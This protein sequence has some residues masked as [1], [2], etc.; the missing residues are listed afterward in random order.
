MISKEF[1]DLVQS[2]GFFSSELKKYEDG[3]SYDRLST[4]KVSFN[5]DMLQMTDIS[6]LSAIAEEQSNVSRM[7]FVYG[8]IYESQNRVLQAL[9]DEYE[10]WEAKIYNV[11][12]Q[13]KSFKTEGAREKHLLQEYENEYNIYKE[14]LRTEKYKLGVLKRTISSLESYSFKLDAVQRSIET[15]IRKMS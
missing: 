14:K 5:S 4:I 3:V 9:E 10:M 8:N 13:D 15:T 11:I 1:E 6:D 2:F 12:S 7:L